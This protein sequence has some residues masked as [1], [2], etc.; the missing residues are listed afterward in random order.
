MYS[1]CCLLKIFQGQLVLEVA[2]RA[3]P[4][5]QRVAPRVAAL[6]P[7]A[8]LDPLPLVAPDFSGAWPI[9]HLFAQTYSSLSNCALAGIPLRRQRVKTHTRL[10]VSDVIMPGM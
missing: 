6:V 2:L 9:H 8:T 5:F 7:L 3:E 4:A 10:V 1:S